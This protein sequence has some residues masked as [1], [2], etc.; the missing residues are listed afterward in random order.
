MPAFS[1]VVPALDEEPLIQGALLSAR[2]AL[3]EDTELL[4]V[5]G[6]SRDRTRERAGSLARVVDSPP[7]RGLQL[8]RGAREASGD[9]LVFLHADTRLPPGSGRAIRDAL[10]EGAGAGCHRFALLG[11]RTLPR[12]LVE[13]AVNLRTRLLRTA[14]G[15]QAVFATREALERAGGVPE[16]PLFEDVELVRRLRR[17]TQFRVLELAAPTSPRRWEERG[18]VRTMLEHVALRLAWWAGVP[19][20]RLDRWYRA[21]LTG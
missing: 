15:D 4:V 6:G 17:V 11:T 2:R 10:A 20:E 3:G 21:R 14:T 12:R 18:Y 8:C 19:P 9:V 13:G 1:V 5:D 16:Q 7:G